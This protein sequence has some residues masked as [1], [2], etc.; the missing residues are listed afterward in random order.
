[1]LG[2]GDEYFQEP[3]SYDT[4]TLKHFCQFSAHLRKLE[5]PGKKNI[6]E[7]C[8]LARDVGSSMN[9]VELVIGSV[10]RHIKTWTGLHQLACWYVLDRLCKESP[11]K[12]ALCA[13]QYVLEIGRDCIPFENRDLQAKYEALIEHWEGV[14]PR[15][16]VDAV[17]MG[18]KERL[19]AT[20]NRKEYEAMLREEEEGWRKT[21]LA[22]QDVD[23]LNNFG[24]PCMD[25]LQG[26]CT[27]GDQCS[28]YHPPGEE[29]SL[30]PECRMGDWKCSSCGV[31]NRH[32]RRRCT[33][34]VREKPQYK[35]E[36]QLALEDKL[37]SSPD[38]KV[39]EI[40][41]QQFGYNPYNET[42]AVAHWR[43][44]FQ[45]LTVQAYRSERRAAY[46]VRI[47]GHKP[48]SALEERSQYQQNFPEPA[49]LDPY[50]EDEDA[51]AGGGATGGL[52]RIR[53]EQVLV[54][55]G[56]P[57]EKGVGILAQLAVER[58]MRDPISPKIFHE[59]G[60]MLRAVSEDPSA[61]LSSQ[62]AERVIAVCRLAATAWKSD[63]DT[64]AFVSTFFKSIKGIE[65]ELGLSVLHVDQL[66]SL[67][68]GF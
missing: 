22:M 50:D 11:E 14:F 20:E 19:W 63:K 5:K 51:L 24:Q 54:P 17:W 38:P 57:P 15:H 43:R 62:L 53:V 37:L 56:V 42:E 8:C 67:F 52:K 40:L 31:I 44:R 30:P 33:N 13:G 4:D 32:F 39:V 21:E 48:S 34:C 49:V 58:G 66:R 65:N 47:L 2:G 46:R 59:L 9:A 25:Y 7:A 18:K 1:M 26:R 28:L 68:E 16:V 64:M 29:G 10:F 12:Y 61:S 55:R 60:E 3:P 23:G 27:W 6:L 45:N 36:R 35:K 41:S